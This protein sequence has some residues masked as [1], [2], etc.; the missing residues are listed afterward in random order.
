MSGSISH[1]E[2]LTYYVYRWK[3][4]EDDAAAVIEAKR[5]TAAHKQKARWRLYQAR[6]GQRRVEAA[7]EGKHS[8]DV[9]AVTESLMITQP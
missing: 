2:H 3:E 9:E 8:L 4:A 1:D 5:V 7:R 6:K